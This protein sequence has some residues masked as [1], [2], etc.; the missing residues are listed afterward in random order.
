[1]KE[2]QIFHYNHSIYAVANFCF[3]MILNFRYGHERTALTRLNPVV[4]T[5]NDFAVNGGGRDCHLI[6]LATL[7]IMNG[8]GV[9]R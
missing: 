4:R 5:C 3:I 6:E 2:D 1:M 7:Q 9:G 8:A